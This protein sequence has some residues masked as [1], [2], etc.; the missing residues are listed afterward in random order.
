MKII[1]V[2]TLLL[3]AAVFSGCAT[4]SELV[5]TC[6]KSIRGDVFGEAPETGPVPQGYTELLV[7]SS[8]KTHK[9]GYHQSIDT[10]GTSEYRL[11]INIDGQTDIVS[12]RLN[13]ENIE[14]RRLRDPEAGEGIRYEFRKNLR[15][16]AGSHKI[17]IVIQDGEIAEER[18]ISL[19][20]GSRN[21]LV[22]E[23]VYGAK[24]SGDRMTIR[25]DKDFY[26]GIEGF[27]II[28]NG[29]TL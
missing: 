16:K 2:L 11:L 14:P 24:R 26:E 7:I 17:A 19:P 20:G 27:R 21:S 8:L 5:R 23:P 13:K 4:N 18:Q 25:T 6:G 1:S 10:H 22:L 3:G 15:L 29:K 28:L 12:G 9:P